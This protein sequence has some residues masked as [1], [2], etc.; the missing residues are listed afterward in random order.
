MDKGK[1]MNEKKYLIISCII[2]V[3]LVI[4]L[5][6]V[7]KNILHL[8]FSIYFFALPWILIAF[9]LVN[10]ILGK[11]YVKK[12]KDIIK[13]WKKACFYICIVGIFV[14]SMMNII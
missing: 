9:N 1:L 10:Y 4:I 6:I 8:R 13:K 14:C 5:P 12:Q 3:I 2:F 7:N 11:I